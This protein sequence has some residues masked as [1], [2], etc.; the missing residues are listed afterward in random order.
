M[1]VYT[2]QNLDVPFSINS[3]LTDMKATHVMGTLPYHHRCLLLTF[4]L[5]TIWMVVFP[6]SLQITTSMI[7]KYNVK[8]RLIRPLS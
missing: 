4:A 8:C 1:A 7:S 5:V 3:A 2:F 6:F